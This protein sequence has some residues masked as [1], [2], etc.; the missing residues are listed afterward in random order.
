[1]NVDNRELPFEPE[2]YELGEAGCDFDLDRREFFRLVGGG[3]V[4]LVLAPFVSAQESGGGRRRRF[5]AP[6]AKE[7]GAWIHIDED[8]QVT[9]YTGKVEF[10]QNIRTSLTQAVAD[11][12]RVSH[13][14]VRLVM[15]DTALVPF[16]MGTFGSMTTATMGAQLRR[17]AAA[18]RNLLVELAAEHWKVNK[19]SLAAADGKVKRGWGVALSYGELTRGKK[20]MQAI[21][22]NVATTP[23]SEWRVA[24][25]SLPKVDGRAIVTGKHRYT[26]DQTRP[27]MLYGRV[28]RPAAFGATLTSADTHSVESVPGTVVV[29]EGDFLAV[30]APS[31]HA[32]DRAAEVIRAEWKT[33]PQP[34]DQE[35]FEYLRK[36][37]VA[38]Q[39]FEG[40]SRQV[41]GSVEKGLAGADHKLSATYTIAYIAHT[42]L[43]PRA[44]LAEWSNGKL[45]VWTGTQR[46]F[47]VRGELAEAFHLDP[48]DVRV[49]VPD[50]GSGY[51]GKHTGETAIEAARIAKTAGKPVKLVW[52]REEEFTWAYA[53][54]GGVIDIKSG[55]RSDGTITAWEFHNYNS[56]ASAMRMRY[57]VPNQHLEF[58]PTKSPLRQGSYRALAATANHFARECHIDEL[59]RAVGMDPLA[60]RLKNLKD[61]RLRRVLDAAAEKFGWGKEKPAAGHGFGIA[62]GF[63]K[64]GYVGC[65]A[66]VAVDKDSG[67]VQVV[68]AVTAFDCGAVVNPEHLTNQI[69]GA[70]M[71]GLGGALFEALHFANGK[72]TNAHFSGYRVPRFSDMPVLETVLVDR[73]DVPSAGA[74]ETPIVGIAPAVGNAIFDATGI[75]LRSMPLAPNGVKAVTSSA[76][77]AGT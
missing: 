8:G 73:K 53:R 14:V 22:D 57:D 17:A 42:P 56:G 23:A 46:P 64:N 26:S 32:A 70:M 68:R 62:G 58:H 29:R 44:A 61:E 11:E 48:K 7:I 18:L 76:A 59:A 60:L 21:G 77:A 54:P 31:Q 45:T 27:G 2:R 51:G 19:E 5:G 71:M 33:T 10:G 37:P 39:G 16:D 40:R 30:A 52:T 69:E 66:E 28:V 20:L 34:S 35:L 13:D 3:V 50:T 67:R 75:R 74:G 36:N 47:G 65:C 41:Q 12:L 43:E 49:V 1:M 63:E 72:V 38:R 9:A 4:V 6:A 25:Q 24:G 15:G 55:V